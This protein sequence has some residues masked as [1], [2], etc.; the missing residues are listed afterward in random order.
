MQEAYE[1]LRDISKR[2]NYDS[3]Y[4]D[5]KSQWTWYRQAIRR[6]EQKQPEQKP[7][8][9]KEEWERSYR[10]RE[11]RPQNNQEERKKAEKERQKAEKK[12]NKAENERLAEEARRRAAARASKEYRKAVKPLR[13]FEGA[14]GLLRAFEAE[15]HEI[16][17]RKG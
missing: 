5:I 14:E 11:C 6:W 13:R 2:T 15:E 3:K 12:R 9:L 10:E 7:R 16:R 4:Q 8:N 17:S 1:I